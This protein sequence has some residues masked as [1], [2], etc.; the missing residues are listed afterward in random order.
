VLIEVVGVVVQAEKVLQAVRVLTEAVGVLVQAV[1][2]LTEVV[3]VVVQAE[4]V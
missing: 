2:V 3:G 4:K 1:R